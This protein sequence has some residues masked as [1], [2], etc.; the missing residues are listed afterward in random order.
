MRRASYSNF[1][2]GDE[3]YKKR[4]FNLVSKFIALATLAASMLAFSPHVEANPSMRDIAWVSAGL[5]GWAAIHP[6]ATSIDNGANIYSVGA[7]DRVD[8]IEQTLDVEYQYRWGQYL[9]W[10]FKPFAGAGVTGRRS[11]YGFSGLE[12]GVHLTPHLVIAPSEALTLYFHGGGKQLG[13]PLEFRSGVDV[14]WILRNGASIGLSYHHMSHWFLF[15]STN[16]GTEI[17]N[18]TVSIPISE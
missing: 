1:R 13:S 6:D 18:L 11:L 9:Q 16:P 12:L 15:G 17:L 4:V 2:F 14:L 10:R 7:F 5:I 3:Y 8:R